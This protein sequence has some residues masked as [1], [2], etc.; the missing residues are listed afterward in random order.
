MSRHHHPSAVA[1]DARLALR[2]GT[3]LQE[4]WIEAAGA[5]LSAQFVIGQRMGQMMAA[6]VGLRPADH[7]EMGRMG[8]EKVEA[9]LAAA[10]AVLGGWVGMQMQLLRFWQR[11]AMLASRLASA[12][13][14]PAGSWRALEAAAARATT[15]GLRMTVANTAAFAPVMAPWYGRVAANARRLTEAEARAAAKA[16]KRRGKR[17]G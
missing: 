17:A 11:E 14:G 15:A 13:N 7:A 9:G 8:S 10:P 3:G 4:A 16:P 12:W 2:A 1:R 5:A 6:G